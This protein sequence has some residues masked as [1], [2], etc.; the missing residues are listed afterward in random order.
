V[1]YCADSFFSEYFFDET[2]TF[3]HPVDGVH[4]TKNV[5]YFVGSVD[6][7]QA[8]VVQAKEVLQFRYA[9]LEEAH[10]LLAFKEAQAV[11]KAVNALGD[12]TGMF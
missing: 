11:L 2:Y 7:Q 10:A 12:S 8:I 1:W 4:V 6:P 5:R 9:S 3:V